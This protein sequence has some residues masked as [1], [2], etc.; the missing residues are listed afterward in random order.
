MPEIWASRTAAA[1]GLYT[2]EGVLIDVS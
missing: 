1:L 2:A